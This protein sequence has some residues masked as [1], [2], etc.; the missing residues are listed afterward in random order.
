MAHI[1]PLWANPNNVSEPTA[2]IALNKS[3]GAR[4]GDVAGQMSGKGWLTPSLFFLPFSYGL[5]DVH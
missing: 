4:S 5:S 2:G 3:G 1:R